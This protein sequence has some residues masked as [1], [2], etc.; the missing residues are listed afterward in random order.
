VLILLFI[1]ASLAALWWGILLAAPAQRFLSK[2]VYSS[3]TPPN[4]FNGIY[5]GDDVVEPTSPD[6]MTWPA[7]TV[8]V[9]GRN[10]GHILAKTLGSLCA[11]DYPRF[12]VVFIDD[13]S[14]DDTAQVCRQ[15]EQKYPH[16]AVIHNQEA[17]RDGW[18][19]KTWAVHQADS[20][21]QDV[22]TDYLLFTD[23]DLEF[24]P[25]CLRHMIRLARHRRTDITSLLPRMLYETTGELLGLLSAMCIIN[26]RLSLYHTNNPKI[27]R[28]LVA[29]GF[30]LV[31]RETYHELGGHAAVRGQVVEDVA[32]GTR[33]KALNKRVFTALT[34]DLYRAR[35]YEGWLDTYRGLK[36]NAYAGANYSPAFAAFIAAFLLFVGALPPLYALAG[37]LACIGYPTALSLMIALVG[38]AA[39]A[40]QTASAARTARFVGFSPWTAL[41]VA[42]AFA[43][44][45]AVFLGSILDYYRGG[46]TWA[47]RR[48]TNAQ[49]LQSA[50]RISENS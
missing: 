17:P 2:F 25:Q 1:L 41:L 29:G 26:S 42:P 35:M 15:L 43:F 21:M 4:R 8:I 28:A 50:G 38:I 48:V 24:H 6:P 22:G 44:Y 19:G 23:S 7:V 27:P 31:K 33:A 9:P 30:L 45:L 34:H 47:G 49:T 32:F 5:P 39:L 36:K 11:M 20:C 18:I 13:Q 10:E 40:F 16:L 46:N 14:T 37:I 3:D 12:R